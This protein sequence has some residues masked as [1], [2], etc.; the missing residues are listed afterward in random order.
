MFN[1][2]IVNLWWI[3]HKHTATDK[4]HGQL[5]NVNNRIIIY[6]IQAHVHTQNLFIKQFVHDCLFIK[7]AYKLITVIFNFQWKLGIIENL[8]N[9]YNLCFMYL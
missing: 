7:V 2:F 1:K 8:E 4:T 6:T 9:R 3:H 5:H